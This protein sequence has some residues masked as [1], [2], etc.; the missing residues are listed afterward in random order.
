MKE[1]WRWELLCIDANTGKELW[2]QVAHKGSPRIK[3]HAS[4]SYASETVVTDEKIVIAY[5]GMT[6]IYCY[7]FT[8]KLLWEKDLGAFKTLNGW[9]TGSS[10]VLWQNTVFVQL[11][12]E[13]NSIITALDATTGKE[14]WTADRDEKTTYSTPVIWQNNLRAEL[15]TN[16][17]IARSYDPASGKMLW[18]LKMAGEMAVP[19]PVYDKEHVYVGIAGG[20]GAKGSLYAVKAGAEGDITPAD[21]G[22]VS[23]GVTWSLPGGGPA[24]PSPILHNGLLYL[25]S[26][27]G[28]V[29]TCVEAATGKQI[30]S[31][32][33]E[34]V[35]ACWATPWICN[36]K[37][38]F[39]DEKGVTQVIQT[40]KE[41][42]V[43]SQNVL[44]D[45]FWASPAISGNNYIF[46]GVGK[47][48]CIG[49]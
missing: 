2:K 46:R 8:G 21:S 48:Y 17:K 45:K 18:Q 29:L 39:Y 16:G 30:Y 23:A 40:G 47:L 42:K 14:K 35:G 49:K 33:I 9:G 44:N 20:R 22:L 5:F 43:L 6:G 34:K 7:D 12:N 19:S 1:V 3:K 13:E 26:G 10:P 28:G 32:K 37:L 41:F 11:D 15:V 31:E 38:Y 36:N 25:L 24:N 27:R 4:T